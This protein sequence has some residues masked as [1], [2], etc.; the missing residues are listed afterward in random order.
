MFTLSTREE[1]IQDF[2]VVGAGLGSTGTNSLRLALDILGFGPS[3]HMKE[4]NQNNEQYVWKSISHLKANG[5]KVE[6]DLVFSWKRFKPYRSTV[7]FPACLYYRELMEYYPKSKVILS[8]REPEKWYDCFYDT[9]ARLSPGHP[10]H[11]WLLNFGLWITPMRWLW[12]WMA[13]REASRFFSKDVLAKKERT[14]NAY[15]DWTEEVK[16]TVP[17]GKLLV[18][19][20][21]SGWEPLCTFLGVSVPMVP[22]PSTN[23]RLTW[24][25]SRLTWKY[26]FIKMQL[27]ALFD[28]V[29]LPVS[30]SAKMLYWV[31]IWWRGGFRDVSKKD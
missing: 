3:Y 24:T 9:I 29:L 13:G 5:G 11:N 25:K 1:R 14:V 23:S 20:P 10:K 15:D 17:K 6:W 30:L 7:D 8:V 16:R 27:K 21:S 22:Y 28:L 12:G 2:R 31:I 19:D 18:F 26:N 4:V